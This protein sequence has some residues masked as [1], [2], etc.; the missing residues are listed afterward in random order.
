MCVCVC[1]GEFH[2]GFEDEGMCLFSQDKTDEFDWTRHS[3]ATRDTK[4]TP[5]TGP[6][7]DHTGSKQGTEPHTHTRQT[8]QQFCSFL[9]AMN[10]YLR[11]NPQSVGECRIFSLSDLGQ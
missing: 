3:A 9:I 11:M 2:C 6:S 7:S 5:N 8:V 10:R 1:P 4:Y